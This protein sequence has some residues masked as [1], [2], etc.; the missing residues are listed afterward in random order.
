MDILDPAT[1]FNAKRFYAY[2]KCKKR[3]AAG[4]LSIQCRE[5][6]KH[7]RS[8]TSPLCDA[9]PDIGILSGVKAHKATGPDEVLTQLLKESADQLA[10]IF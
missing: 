1:V 2:V 3:M 10:P 5:T 9:M 4:Y 6:L 7:N 8:G